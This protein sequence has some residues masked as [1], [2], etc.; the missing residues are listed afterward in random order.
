MTHI[1]I[2]IYDFVR[3]HRRSMLWLLLALIVALGA[4]VSRLEY[5]EQITDFLPIDAQYQQALDVYQE[6]ASGNRVVM[7][8][9]CEDEC[10]D[11][12]KVISAVEEHYPPQVDAGTVL[13]TFEFVFTHLPYYLDEQDYARVDSLW[14]SDFLQN[15]FASMQQMLGGQAGL[16]VTPMLQNDP[17]GLG[18]RV[19]NSLRDFQPNVNCIQIDGYLFTPDSTRMLVPVVSPYGNSETNGNAR[20]IAELQQEAD[21]VL[22]GS[23]VIMRPIGAPVVAVCNSSQI[24]KDATMSVVIAVVLIL[25]LLWWQFRNLKGLWYILLSTGFGFLVALAMI[26][27]LKGGISVIVIGMASTIIGIAVNY[28]LHYVCHLQEVATVPFDSSKG[29]NGSPIRN[30]LLQLAS[31]LLIGNITTV[32]AFMA[33]VPLDA[34][35]TSD[36][37]LFAA[38]MLIGTIVF[39]LV[40]LPHISGDSKGGKQEMTPKPDGLGTVASG[41]GTGASGLGTGSG[42]FGRIAL[43]SLRYAKWLACVFLILTPL[44]GWLSMDI[45]FDTN[46][47]NI[48]YMT[49]EMR[50]DLSVLQLMDG[51]PEG[52]T[53]VY[54]TAQ[55]IEDMEQMSGRLDSLRQSGDV[56]GLCNPAMLMPSAEMQKHRL[57]LWREY[58]QRHK[59]DYADF[60]RQ[61]VE[62]GFSEGAFAPFGEMLSMDEEILAPEDFELLTSTM[63]AGLVSAKDSRVVTRMYVPLDKVEKV[64]GIVNTTSSDKPFG[65]DKPR[66]A[67]VTKDVQS[68]F[69]FNMKGMNDRVLS[70]LTSD[71]NYIGFVCSLIVFVFLWI[72]FG[73]IELAILA[74]IPMAVGWLWILGL[75]AALD[76]QFNIVNVILATFIFGQGDD[77]T[78]FVVEG[79]INDYKE[80]IRTGKEV[81][82]RLMSYGRS[83]LLSSLIML[84]GMGAMVISEHPALLSLAHV[85]LIG[86]GVVVLMAWVLPPVIFSWLIKV[87]NPLKKYILRHN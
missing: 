14:D 40:V 51:Q 35:A 55:S 81:H 37:G 5:K 19:A 56:A 31:P 67:V 60:K 44:M 21:S 41:L 69:A 7:Q 48:N 24:R 45:Q 20:F 58:W 87:D 59:F 26:S 22:T 9:M 84:I 74:F 77:Y 18:A 38:I 12:Q 42:S 65:A 52:T 28:P 39:V 62:A 61:A 13:E 79:L 15:R 66:S 80:S 64:E 6:V 17:L 47:N 29:P 8:F 25:A 34:V 2:Y 53:Q 16:F 32:G 11:P 1:I 43:C 50:S 82:T 46:L 49:P 72:S 63:L 78:I 3:G 73:R 10:A 30:T 70:A 83:I 71:F 27:L 23:S 86:M 33:L 85:T 57:Q 76:V 36:L 68:T 75:M 4:L 54:V